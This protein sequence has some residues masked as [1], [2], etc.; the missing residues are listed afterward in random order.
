MKFF[1]ILLV[2]NI[3]SPVICLLVFYGEVSFFHFSLFLFKK[4]ISKSIYFIVKAFNLFLY[5]AFVLYISTSHP[6]PRWNHKN[7][8]L[9]ILSKLLT[10][11]EFAVSWVWGQF[12]SVAQL[13]PTLWDPMD[14][15]MLG[16]PVIHQLPE[17][18]QTHV[19]CIS[20]AIQPSHPLLSPS[21]PAFNLSQY[22]G[23]FHW[24]SSSHHVAKVLEFQFQHQFFQ[25]IFRTD[26]L[27][28]GL[29]GSPCCSRDSQESPPTPQFKSTNSSVLSF[30]YS[31]ALTSTHDYCKNHSFE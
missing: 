1:I 25:W 13:C 29:L 5:L 31:P 18:T 19:H 30:L 8:Q 20:D 14:Y 11:L 2:V 24:V 3:Y 22:Q 7:I 21:P 10:Y 26:F 4:N 27:W 23:P 15:S 16:F 28:D 6:I 12:S 9:Y 17:P